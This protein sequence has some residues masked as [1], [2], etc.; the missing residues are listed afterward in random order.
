MRYLY[1]NKPAVSIDSFT[2]FNHLSIPKKKLQAMKRIRVK[3]IAT[4]VIS[5]AVI[6][7]GCSKEQHEMKGGFSENS[8]PE[9]FN[10]TD[11][12]DLNCL[13]NAPEE[14]TLEEVDMLLLM[15][16]EEKMAR[17]VYLTLSLLYP[18]H[19]FVKI[20][21]SEQIHMEKVT[22]LL[23]HYL[24]E[25]T[26]HEE[27]G[28]FE[29]EDMQTLYTDFVTRGEVDLIEALTVGAEIEDLDIVD[30]W[31]F[32][33]VTENGAIIS[34]FDNLACGSSNHLRT[35]NQMLESRGTDFV[36]IYLSQEDFDAIIESEH[37][38][39]GKE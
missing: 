2:P 14:L 30:L 29:N 16:E 35:F 28:A 10:F 6:I 21:E 19:V 9:T 23:N 12:C 32:M 18:Q 26:L 38:F 34:I 31:E 8:A 11:P 37:Q 4:I 5:A 25:Y 27:I 1:I 15:Q 22:C 20:S 36:P 3:S 13:V 39:C 24:I 7:S 17:D 33:K